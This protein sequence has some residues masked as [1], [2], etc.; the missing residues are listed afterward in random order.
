VHLGAESLNGV[1]RTKRKDPG[2]GA[3][4][5]ALFTASIVKGSGRPA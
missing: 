5:G 3:A 4:S 2:E 1:S